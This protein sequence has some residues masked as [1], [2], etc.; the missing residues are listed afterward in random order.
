MKRSLTP[1]CQEAATESRRQT[2]RQPGEEL[3]DPPS[4]HKAGSTVSKGIHRLTRTIQS[5][6][7]TNAKTNHN[8]SKGATP[9]TGH[10]HN[11]R[12]ASIPRVSHFY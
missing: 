12:E 4:G 8:T 7:Q 2:D 1:G 11:L 3:Q 6:L 9:E 5:L 10:Y